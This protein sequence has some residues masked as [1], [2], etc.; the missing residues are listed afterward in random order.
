MKFYDL[1]HVLSNDMP[2]WEGA[3]VPNFHTEGDV[4]NGDFYQ[5]TTI[6]DMVCHIGTHIDCDSHMCP[7]GFYTDTQDMG[8]WAGKGLILDVTGYAEG[9]EIGMEVFDDVELDGVEYLLVYSGWSSRWE[10]PT[11]F[12]G[13]YAVF[14]LE[15]MEFLAAH[16]TVRGLCV[17]TNSVDIYGVEGPDSQ[18]RHKTFLKNK[19][20]ITE[21]LNLECVDELK[22][23]NFMYI[24]A[25]L[26]IKRGEGSPVRAMA[27]VLD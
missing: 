27:I 1:T 21:C 12:Y 7:N 11:A 23:K 6:K 18:I 19:T 5:L 26:K 8:Y 22:G 25:P 2:Y 24:A 17:E 14:S 9:A 10:D 3:P 20:T 4:N 15:V 16:P 13:N